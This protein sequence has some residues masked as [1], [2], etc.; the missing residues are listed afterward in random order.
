MVMFYYS[1]QGTWS[2]PQDWI[3]NANY[4]EQDCELQFEMQA[5]NNLGVNGTFEKCSILFSLVGVVFG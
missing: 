3:V 4:N 1:L 5:N 2:M